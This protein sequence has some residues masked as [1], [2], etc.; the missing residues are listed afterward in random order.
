MCL[1]QGKMLLFQEFSRQMCISCEGGVFPKAFPC[2]WL[3]W[4]REKHLQAEQ[5]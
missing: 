2:P 1:I 3:S 4:W 5:L